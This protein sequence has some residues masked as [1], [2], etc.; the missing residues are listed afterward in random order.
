MEDGEA[1]HGRRQRSPNIAS[2]SGAVPFGA[3]PGRR[4][5][6]VADASIGTEPKAILTGEVACHD[7]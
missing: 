7:T 3:K 1:G 6:A 2:K 4:W 5:S